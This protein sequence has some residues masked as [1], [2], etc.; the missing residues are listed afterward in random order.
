MYFSLH[1]QR[2]AEY[3]KWILVHYDTG[4]AQELTLIYKKKNAALVCSAH[5]TA[6]PS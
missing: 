3:G 2:S 4:T 1:Y 5:F 6:F